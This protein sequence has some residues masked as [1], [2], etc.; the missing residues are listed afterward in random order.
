MEKVLIRPASMEDVVDLTPRLRWE[1]VEE[2][3]AAGLTVGFALAEGVRTPGA[4]AYTAV[5]Q[6]TGG[7]IAIFGAVPTSL[8][9]DSCVVWLLGSRRVDDC[10]FEY[11][12]IGKRFLAYL[13]SRY[14][15]LFNHVD[16]RSLR[17]IR[18][19]KI[20]GFRFRPELDR[21]G[22]QSKFLYFEMEG[23][24]ACVTR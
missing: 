17:S 12:H 22:C 21:Q 13:R 18:M 23:D 10:K 24:T 7:R 3:Y 20:L 2:V 4:E 8:A 1:D 15:L 6:P 9:G 19:L 16:E 5:F 11:L 14:R